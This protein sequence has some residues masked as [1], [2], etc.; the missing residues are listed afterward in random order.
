MDLNARWDKILRDIWDNKARSLL[1]IFT[2]AIGIAAVGLINNGVRMMKR[3][4][5]GQFKERNPASLTLYISPFPE[6]LANDVE[7]MREV[8]I[9]RPQRVVS[10]S[11]LTPQGERKP[12]DLIA[13]PDFSDLPINRLVVE[14]G[15]HT[16][17]LRQIL[18]ERRVANAF[19]LNT[20]D[21]F[22]VEMDG[23]ARYTLTVGGLVHD[24][25]V[26][27]FNLTGEATG[28]LS[29]PTLEWMGQPAYYNQIQLLVA[30]NKTSREHV[31]QVGAQARDRIV[32]PG[33]YQVAA[34]SVNG[35]PNPNPGEFWAKDQVSGVML[36]LQVMSILAI[37]LCSGLVVNTI[38]AVLVQQTRQIGIMRSV[39][40]TR[41]Q[42]VQMYLAYVLVLSII[43][44]LVAL[45]L[46]LLGAY[47]LL[48]VAAD[49]LNFNISAV[50]LPPGILLLQAGLGIAM[51]MAV[52]LL[53]I[54]RGTQLSVYDAIYQYGLNDEDKKGWLERQLIRLRKLSP[55]VMLSLRNTFRNKSRLIFTLA[56]LTIAG[57][58]FMAVFSSYNTIHQ[59]LDD[60]GRYIA[61]DVSLSIPGGANKHTVEREALRI[62]D[63]QAAEGWGSAIGVI[64]RPDGQ[65]SGRLELVGL[66]Q[67]PQTIQPRLVQGRWLQPGDT[68]QVV[69]N[70]DLLSREPQVGVGD[71]LVVKI[72]GQE[73]EL[74]VVGVVS[75]HLTGPRIYM[76]YTELTRLTGRHNQVDVVR[77]LATPGTFGQ[78]DEQDAI[79]QQLEKRFEDAELSE[80]AS[81]TRFEV[82]DTISNAFDILLIV[83]LLVAGILAVIGGLSL[84]GAMGLN[85]L[86]RTREIGVLRAVGASHNSVRQVVVV[87]GATVALISWVLSALISYPAGLVL[88]EAV[89]RM[90]FGTQA[91]FQYSVLGLLVWLAAV[92]LIGVL[93]SLAPARNA[94]RLTVR[95]VL[96]YE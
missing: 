23:G 65:E 39:G 59:Q 80:S 14:E 93:A 76:N 51:P 55:P 67:N 49:Y 71:L 17:G 92:V 88:S 69:V 26:R 29:L 72:N 73:R 31:L 87:E 16:P 54:L 96:S 3:D 85:V 21:T 35:E 75:K 58:M 32:E 25:T 81:R 12:I 34:M 86:E 63:I 15:S 91:T 24:M 89:V 40:A 8:E 27:P 50:D 64:I 61:F 37:L 28:Y 11:M 70:E 90:S 94:V 62:A 4:L 83:L 18:L 44:M 7:G 41:R 36:V 10:A 56:T 53:P 79:G 60:L 77:V 48:V 95:E 66:P 30:E 38:S 20:G 78:P 84:T 13:F 57:A 42:M 52:A 82:F 68:H 33:G 6:S 19:G 74:E 22:T 5:Y 43:G 46:G 2:L 9:A 47:G 45:P 1:V